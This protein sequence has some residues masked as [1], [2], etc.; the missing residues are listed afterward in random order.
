M[1]AEEPASTSVER[2]PRAVRWTPLVVSSLVV[3]LVLAGVAGAL[4]VRWLAPVSA[5]VCDATAVARS[6]LPSV[7]TILTTS[8]GG[9][10]GNGTGELIRSGGYVLTN[11][12]VIAGAADNGT[13]AVRYSDGT[14]SRARIAGRDTDTDLAVLKADDGAAG[15]PLIPVGSSESV[16]VGQPVVA[17]GA[18]L[19]LSSTVTAGILSALGRYVPVPAPE[20]GTAHLIDALQTDAAIN[21]GNSGGPLVDCDGALVGVNTAIATV[22]NSAGVGGGGSVG[23]GFAIPADLA[24]PISDQL[25]ATGRANHPTLGLQAQ[26]LP[27]FTDPQSGQQTGVVITEVDAGGPAEAAGLRV[28][29]VIT[30]VD[31]QPTRSVDPLTISTLTRNPGDSIEIAYL[32]EGRPGT[33][34]VVLAA[35]T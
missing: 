19:G 17:L 16:D 23:L 5:R 28:G 10:G 8:A 14:T 3:A 29:D 30:A 22:P 2:R 25:I 11:D 15:R 9:G 27:W 21:P 35:A 33:A 1:A 12:H 26:P 4:L 18:P 20:G 13:V 6:T 7:V 32:R 31:G 24:V 34:Q